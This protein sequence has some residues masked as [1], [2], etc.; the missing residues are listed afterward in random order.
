MA[1]QGREISGLRAAEPCNHTDKWGIFALLQILVLAYLIPL[2]GRVFPSNT[3]VRPGE[4]DLVTAT[5]VDAAV[6]GSILFRKSLCTA[7]RTMSPCWF[8][9][10]G[11][12][13]EV[14][15]C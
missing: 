12:G 1:V 15:R 7:R 3:A 5:S 6:A 10:P 9:G 4:P 11:T 2:V 14:S 8:I 13:E